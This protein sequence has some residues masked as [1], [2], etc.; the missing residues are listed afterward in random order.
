MA[1]SPLSRPMAATWIAGSAHV[2]LSSVGFVKLATASAAVVG[3]GARL[4]A[5][6]STVAARSPPS[7]GWRCCLTS[8]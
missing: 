1:R 5:T 7:R 3:H 2:C 6:A 4:V 8:S